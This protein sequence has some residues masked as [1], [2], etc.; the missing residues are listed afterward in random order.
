MEQNKDSA[1]NKDQDWRLLLIDN[2][3]FDQKVE[4]S[5]DKVIQH[6]D[7]LTQDLDHL[8]PYHFFSAIY[9]FTKAFKRFSNALS[10]GFSDITEK[11]QVWRNLFKIHSETEINDIQSL[12]QKEMACGLQ[13]LN[14]ENNSKLGHKKGTTYYNYV[15]GCRTM[16]RLS[17]FLNFL[18]QTFKNMLNSTDPFNTCIKKAY[19]SALGPHHNWIIKKSVGLILNAAGS[20]R[21][22]ALL[23]FFGKFF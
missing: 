22:P 19:E 2:K 6:F 3:N 5:L 17:W 12:M 16:V 23:A 8:N 9:E 14:G 11:V 10:M 15:S 1:E 18:Y 4:Y 13:N 20:N 21:E 7:I